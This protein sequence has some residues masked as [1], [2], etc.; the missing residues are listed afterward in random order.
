MPRVVLSVLLV[1]AGGAAGALT[2]W[3]IAEACARLLGKAMP[4]GTL[5]ANLL[6]CLLI[7]LLW[8]VAVEQRLSVQTQRLIFVGFLGALTTF[9]TFA[10]ESGRLLTARQFAPAL[11]NV[12]G[13][14]VAGIA[15]VYVGLALGH[16]LM[17]AGN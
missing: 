11:A 7:G 14:C 13:S 10:L 17:P 16:K 4:W 1:A 5:A 3:G 2:R 12:L 8:A 9:S 6:G 15:L